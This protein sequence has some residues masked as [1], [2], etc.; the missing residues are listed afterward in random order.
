MQE[1]TEQQ[2]PEIQAIDAASFTINCTGD[3]C[4]GD[5]ILFIEPVFAGSHRAPSFV[6]D[7]RVVARVLKDSYG[8][9]KQQH[10]FTLEIL[11]SDGYQPLTAG[12]RTNRKG[13]NVYGNGTVRR[14]WGD[15]TARGTALSDKHARGET[16]RSKRDLRREQDI[17]ARLPKR[18]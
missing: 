11:A 6:G 7:R 14:P 5:V 2:P 15:E 17:L 13:R 3:V 4:Q 9:K 18:Y 10:T 12:K 1:S 8:A 16:A